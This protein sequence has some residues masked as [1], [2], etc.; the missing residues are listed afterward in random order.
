[1]NKLEEKNEISMSCILKVLKL[2]IIGEYLKTSRTTQNYKPVLW[3]GMNQQ[4]HLSACG[5]GVAQMTPLSTSRLQQFCVYRW[6][7]DL[8]LPFGQ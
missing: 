8:E 3:T 7:G 5:E 2:R 1:M 4:C 6:S